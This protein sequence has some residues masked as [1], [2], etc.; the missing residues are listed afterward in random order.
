[1]EEVKPFACFDKYRFLRQLR[2]ERCTGWSNQGHSSNI[3]RKRDSRCTLPE[4][5]RRR[6]VCVK[7]VVWKRGL[8]RTA[9]K[10]QPTKTTQPHLNTTTN[11][12]DGQ[13]QNY[14]H[15]IVHLAYHTASRAHAHR[16]KKQRVNHA[17]FAA[18]VCAAVRE[19]TGGDEERAC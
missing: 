11:L 15:L 3:G 8:W 4:C 6:G 7:L 14:T 10:K 9:K 17:S 5:P 12:T 16:E 13:R 2:V 1:M 19:R 18:A